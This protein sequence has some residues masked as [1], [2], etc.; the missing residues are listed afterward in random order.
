MTNEQDIIHNSSLGQ[1]TNYTHQYDPNLLFPIPRHF[2]R[3]ELGITEPLPFYGYDTWNDYE[4]SWLN[5]Q[6]KPIVAITEF[7]IPCTSPNIIE[8]KSLKLYLNALAN[9]SFSS[10][11]ELQTVL[12][13]DLSLAAGSEITVVI[14]PLDTLKTMTIAPPAGICIDSLNIAIDTYEAAPHYLTHENNERVTETLY[15]HL[16]KSNCP[17]TKQPDWGTLIIDY[18]GQKI[19]RAGLLRYVVS[20][21][22]QYEFHEQC[23]E[24]I[25]I[26]I[27]QHCQP[28][29][30]TLCG[31]Y[32]RRGGK[33]IN[34]Y[35]STDKNI[36]LMNQRLVR[37]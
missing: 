11:S 21:R 10:V 4:T 26:N 33:D 23:I 14:H 35:R 32:T 37:Q 19:S 13:R 31:R 3:T 18:A 15:T 24:R 2:K 17:V 27:M 5:A 7:H 20:L 6:G 22:N 30:L 34:P 1:Q 16:L 8:S 28:S 9:T 29:T 36:V 25:F 12:Q